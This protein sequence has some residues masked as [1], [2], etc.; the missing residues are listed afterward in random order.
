MDK[1]KALEFIT[2]LADGANPETG[3]AMGSDS[4]FNQPDVIRALFVAKQCIEDAITKEKRETP[5]PSNAGKPWSLEEDESL[6]NGFSAGLM[7]DELAKQ[8]QRTK[9]S[10]S[11]RLVRLGLV[12]ADAGLPQ[13]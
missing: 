13:R 10:I 4:A 12:S 1:I 3:E 11:S 8:H 9:G 7:V 5:L 6:A 2:I